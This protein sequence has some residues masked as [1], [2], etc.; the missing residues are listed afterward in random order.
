MVRRVLANVGRGLAMGA[1]DVV[2]GV[3]GGTVALLLGIYD[4]LVGQ[5]A[6]LSAAAAA[7]LR[8]RLR[9]AFAMALRAEWA[10]LVALVAGIGI[11]ILA[12]VEVVRLLID[13]QPVGLSAAFFGLVA[14]TV[15]TTRS[16]VGRWRVGLAGIFVTVGVA[17]FLLLGVRAGSVADPGAVV[18][19]GAGALAI[20][21]MILP[22][23][24]GAFVLLLLGLYDPITKAVSD[25]DVGTVVLFG[26][27]AVLGL[28]LFSRLLQRLLERWRDAVIAALMG[29]MAGSLRVLWPWP[30]GDPDAEGF[31]NAALGAPPASELAV[32]VIAAVAAGAVAVAL[33]RMGTRQASS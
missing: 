15:V 26:V 25:R 32:A 19:V 29:L 14:V 12:L 20:C 2:P 17:V 28:G 23:I 3:S 33:Y 7:A 1:A 21:A 11:A 24:S 9:S 31:G 22:G 30:V 8:G 27:G 13:E 16:Q 6:H 18:I 4:R 10:F 5:I